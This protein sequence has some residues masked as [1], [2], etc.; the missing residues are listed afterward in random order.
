LNCSK[1]RVTARLRSSGF[2][3]TGFAERRAESG[4]GRTPAERAGVDRH[5]RRREAAVGE[6]LRQQAAGRV[7][8]DRGLLV[9]AREHL[10]GVVGDHP[11]RLLGE[12]VGVGASLLD[13][14]RVVRPGRFQRRAR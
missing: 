1:V 13:R 11:Q 7:A 3:S 8:E 14:A 10:L 12:D 5:R 6:D 4:S 9:E 2:C